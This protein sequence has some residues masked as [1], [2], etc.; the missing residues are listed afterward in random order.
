M[1]IRWLLDGFKAIRW[2]L[3]LL[4]GFKASQL[5]IITTDKNDTLFSSMELLEGER[6]VSGEFSFRIFSILE[7]YA[8]NFHGLGK[9][10]DYQ[11]KFYTVKPIAVPPQP[12]PNHLIARVGDVIESMI[13]EGVIEEHPPNKPIP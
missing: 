4:G 13:K 1:V 11:V 5:K 6:E 10:N 12:I 2:L 9:M 7:K 8:E 3:T